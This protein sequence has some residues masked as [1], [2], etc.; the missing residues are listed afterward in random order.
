[1]RSVLVVCVVLCATAQSAERVER[2]VRIA[3]GPIRGYKEPGENVFSFYGIPYATAPTGPHRFKAPLPAPSWLTT[4]E[5]TNKD[6]ICPQAVTPEMMAIL[7]QNKVLQENCLIANVFVPDTTETNLPVVVY[8]HGGAYQVGHG[9]F[10]TAN[11]LLKEKPVILVTFNYRLGIH[12]FLCLGTEDAPGNAGMKDQVAL[13]RWVKNNIATFGGNPD[14]VTIAGYSAG[15]S[16]VDLLMLSP[17]TKGLF[18]KVIPESGAN[19]AAFSVQIDPIENAKEYAKKFNVTNVDDVFALEDFYRT[20]PLEDLFTDSFMTR[21][22]SVFVFSP[23]V[24][25]KTSEEPFLLESPYAILSSGKYEKVPILY[26]FANMEGLMRTQ[27]FDTWKDSMN[28]KFSDF[29]PADLQFKNDDEKENVAKQVKEFYFGDKLI[30]EETVLEYI[31]YFSDVIFTYGTLR[32]VKLHV[33]A[34]N[35]KIY[36]Y[37]YSFTDDEDDIFLVPHTDNVRGAT[38]CA[39]TTAVF[40]AHPFFTRSGGKISKEYKNMRAIMRELWSN[41]IITGTPVPAGSSL[42]AWPP[43]GADGAP[44]M[45]LGRTVEL[46]GALLERRMRFWDSIYEKHYREPQPPPAPPVRHTEL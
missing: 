17:S 30:S 3:Q 21:K 41:F 36:L 42:P 18:N 6:I 40:D 2:I 38:H 32:A 19:L 5:A 43:T 22:D 7:G 33:K 20:A 34:G 4:F 37:E 16:S 26:G 45:S 24:E 1:M 27:Y 29:L 9:N 11:E 13:L 8:V 39:Q 31:D 44:H 28:E 15:S 12:G 23:C 35:N 10:L 14:D 46:R 25:R